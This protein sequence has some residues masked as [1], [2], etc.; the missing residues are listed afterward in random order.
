MIESQ[1][2]KPKFASSVGEYNLEAEKDENKEAD[3]EDNS[4][5]DQP[6]GSL[7]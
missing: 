2:A 5:D 4:S 3:D 6:I 1:V 7:L